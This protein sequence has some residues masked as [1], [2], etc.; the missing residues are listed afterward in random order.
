MADGGRV[1]AV[2]VR[3][4]GGQLGGGAPLKQGVEHLMGVSDGVGDG[5][6]DGDGDSDGVGMGVGVGVGAWAWAWAWVWAW[7]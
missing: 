5:V 2:E 7:T 3:V 6:G 1:A 4:L